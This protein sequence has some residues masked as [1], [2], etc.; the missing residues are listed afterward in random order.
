M[1]FRF[2]RC[3]R[4]HWAGFSENR[5][6]RVLPK[7]TE[8]II[9]CF[10]LTPSG[11]SRVLRSVLYDGIAFDIRKMTFAPLARLRTSVSR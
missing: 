3:W 4:I 1:S 10:S 11:S 8:T 9:I 7:I 6:C 2:R 5:P